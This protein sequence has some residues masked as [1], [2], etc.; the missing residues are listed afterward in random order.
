MHTAQFGETAA[1]GREYDVEVDRVTETDWYRAASRFADY[2]FYQTWAYDVRRFGVRAM[3]HVLVRR[4][5]IVVAAA[6]VRLVR[7]PVVGDV[8]AYIRWGPMWRLTGRRADMEAFRAVIQAVKAEYVGRRGLYLRIFPAL[9]EDEAECGQILCQ[10]GFVPVSAED[11][12][13]TLVM[14]LRPSGAEIRQKL[15]KKWRNCLNKAEAADLRLEEGADDGLFDAFI[16]MYRELV[17]RKKFSL[18]NDIGEFRQAQRQLPE[19]QKLRLFICHGSGGLAAGAICSAIGDTGV[20]L[21]GATTQYGLTNKA[22]YLVQWRALHAIKEAGC[23]FYNLNGID[24]AKNPGTYHFKVGLN[25]KNGRDLRYLGRFDCWPERA[26]GAMLR[27]VA[28]A[29]PLL[30]RLRRTAAAGA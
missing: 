28:A 12:G 17:S 16:E 13:R 5:G 3:S 21:F 18:P 15:E 6:Q 20:Y 30:A 14:D 11:A 22:S 7:V 4:G 27:R 10:E 9:Y 1:C 25:H 26:S 2:N 23:S 29:Y 8:G 19:S 24:P